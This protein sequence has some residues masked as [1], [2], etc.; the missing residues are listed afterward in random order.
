MALSKLMK[1]ITMYI[2]SIRLDSEEQFS[3]S[4]SEDKKLRIK[5]F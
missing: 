2:R 1:V 5:P 4:I 3:H